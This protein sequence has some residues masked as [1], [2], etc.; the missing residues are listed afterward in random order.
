MIYGSGQPLLGSETATAL[1]V[2][3]LWVNS[4]KESMIDAFPEWFKG[5]GKLR[6]YTVKLHV[7]DDVKPT[8]QPLRRPPYSLRNKIEDTL[9]ELEELDITDKVDSPSVWI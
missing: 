2:L 9:V 7:K 4:I 3:K 5:V 6:D 8:I 1:G